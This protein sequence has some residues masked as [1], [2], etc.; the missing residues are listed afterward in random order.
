MK[1]ITDLKK[2]RRLSEQN[3][4]ENWDFR[5]FL[6]VS[7]MDIEEMDAIVHEVYQEI[8]AAIDCTKCA[9]CCRIVQPLLDREDIKKCSKGLGIPGSQ[10]KKKYLKP[11]REED[12]FVFKETPCPFLENS[13]CRIYPHRPNDCRSFP[14]LHKKEFVFRLWGVVEN[15]SICPIVFNVYEQLKDELWHSG[16]DVFGNDPEDIII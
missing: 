8:S 2:I 5:A 6:K 13:L 3:D 9:N 12:R 10:F 15:C 16:D 14:H 7:D 1:L 4:S 11:D